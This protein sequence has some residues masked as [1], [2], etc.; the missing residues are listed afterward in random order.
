METDIF[1]NIAD[2][3][4]KEYEKLIKKEHQFYIPRTLEYLAVRYPQISWNDFRILYS[5]IVAKYLIIHNCDYISDIPFGYAEVKQEFI[6]SLQEKYE[7][8]KEN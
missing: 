7:N 6:E 5:S 1:K 4:K 2:N 8:R 3:Y